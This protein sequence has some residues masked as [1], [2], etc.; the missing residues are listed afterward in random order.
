MQQSIPLIGAH[1]SFHGSDVCRALH[2]NM[3]WQ[4]HIS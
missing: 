3:T 1:F 2:M 4:C